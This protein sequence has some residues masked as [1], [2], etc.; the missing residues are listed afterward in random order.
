MQARSHLG[1]PFGTLTVDSADD[2]WSWVRTRLGL[3]ADK[4]FVLHM[5]RHSTA[6]RLADAGVDAFRIQKM[7][8][9]KTIMTTQKYVHVSAEALQGLTGALEA[10][11]IVKTVGTKSGGH[12]RD[13][14]RV[15]M[16]H[17]TRVRQ[18]AALRGKR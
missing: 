6:S 1:T 7:M 10:A 15:N 14:D 8:G 12:K 16:G 13:P 2:E 17:T 3:D 4:E 9:H 18:P 11:S 5:L